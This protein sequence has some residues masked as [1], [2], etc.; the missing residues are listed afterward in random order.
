MFSKNLAPGTLDSILKPAGSKLYLRTEEGD[1][2]GFCRS[3]IDD[4]YNVRQV[5]LKYGGFRY[6]A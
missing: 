1:L 6:K 3:L 2:V 5:E 4:L